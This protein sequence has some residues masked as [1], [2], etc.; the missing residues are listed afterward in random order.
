MSYL[1]WASY[2]YLKSILVENRYNPDFLLSA[3]ESKE[4]AVALLSLK[5]IN[6]AQ[7][8]SAE[9]F[10]LINCFIYLNL[11]IKILLILDD[12]WMSKPE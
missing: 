10:P 2:S 11:F 12:L 9:P 6:P 1:G 7:I 5:V 8:L 3:S 4:A